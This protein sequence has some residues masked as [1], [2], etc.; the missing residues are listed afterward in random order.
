MRRRHYL[1]LLMT[2][3]LL[4]LVVGCGV[5]DEVDLPDEGLEADIGDAELLSD[6]ASDGPIYPSHL[7]CAP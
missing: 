6:H 2:V 5:R 4:A 1:K 7:G 3:S